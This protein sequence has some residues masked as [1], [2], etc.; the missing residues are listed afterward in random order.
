MNLGKSISVLV[1][2]LLAA[3]AG[4]QRPMFPGATANNQAPWSNPS[5]WTQQM[6][7]NGSNAGQNPEQLA[8]LTKQLAD[9]NAQLTRFDTDN[10]GLYTQ[11]AALQQKLDTAN[12][13]NY[14][15]KQQLRD[16]TV[17]LQQ[18]QVARDA[19]EQRLAAAANSTATPSATGGNLAQA[20][21]SPS[22]PYQLAGST[23]LRA[24]NSLLGK[25]EAVQAAGVKA[26]MDGDLI[27]MEFPSDQL[28]TPGTFELA[29]TQKILLNNVASTIRQHFPR[30]FIGI[31]AHWDST[32]VSGAATSL[33]QLTASQALAVFNHLTQAGL[34]AR[35][36]FTVGMADNRPRY[37]GPQNR[38]IEIV[39]YPE[40]AGL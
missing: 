21:P 32:P 35:Q 11:V 6:W 33:Q 31:E 20:Q 25:L 23:T 7:G 19:A 10:Q 40:T 22:N 34:P 16:A 2:L 5:Q 12:T 29:G 18:V 28:F 13:Y 38:R 36:L 39:I 15:L 26:W 14:Q 37:T 17:Q 30:Q 8:Q 1:L 9:V 4:C 3:A 24:N 27:R